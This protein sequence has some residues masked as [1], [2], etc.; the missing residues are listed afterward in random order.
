MNPIL[1]YF[2]DQLIESA[3]SFGV[4][5]KKQELQHKDLEVDSYRIFEIPYFGHASGFFRIVLEHKTFEKYTKTFKCTSKVASLFNELL[6]LSI[7]ATINHFPEFDDTTIGLAK[8]FSSPVYEP[9]LHIKE[10]SI[11]D[12]D[13]QSSISIYLHHDFRKTEMSKV[14]DEQQK[15]KEEISQMALKLEEEKDS[16]SNQRFEAI[17]QLAAGV[18]HEINTPIQFVSD[19]IN[20]LSESFKK[21]LQNIDDLKKINMDFYSEEIPAALKE[22]KEGLAR[23]STI[24]QSLKE[25][26]HPGNDQVQLYPVRQLIDNCISLTKN[27]FKYVADIST[28][29]EDVRVRTY[30][31]ELGQVLV[32]MIINSSHSIRDKF[33]G[34]KHGLISIKFYKEND[35]FIF[36]IEDNGGGIDKA[37]IDKVFNPFYTTKAVGEGTGQGLAISKKIITEKHNG[38]ISV[39]K[40]SKDG[41]C[42]KVLIKEPEK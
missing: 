5:L 1:P 35:Y 7:S 36:E 38:E 39:I 19:N 32:N 27:E 9:T 2:V 40:N 25:F 18:A 26:S 12:V 41:L 23:I 6:N 17:G 10:A 31:N 37:H 16:L 42:F 4:S 30:P 3:K 24:I 22:S 15:E 14:F 33:G 20:F 29:I 13:C 8:S 28:E 34:K 11:Y 21:I